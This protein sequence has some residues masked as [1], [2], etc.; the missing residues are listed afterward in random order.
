MKKRQLNQ[1]PTILC[2]SDGGKPALAFQTGAMLAL[3]EMDLLRDLTVFCG[4]GSGNLFLGL[5]FDSFGIPAHGWSEWTEKCTNRHGGDPSFVSVDLKDSSSSSLKLS[6]LGRLSKEVKREYNSYEDPDNPH[7]KHLLSR[8]DIDAPSPFLP[9][10]V[11]DKAELNPDPLHTVFLERIRQY[12]TTNL[13]LR[14]LWY[15][16]AKPPWY[17]F[18]PSG[19]RDYSCSTLALVCF[20]ALCF[21]I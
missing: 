20:L 2:I 1:R 10:A 6:R 3:Y 7:A 9:T 4:S 11:E 12:C 15:R 8:A 21:F 13:E 14:M 19:S 18:N 17:W 5:L 16:F